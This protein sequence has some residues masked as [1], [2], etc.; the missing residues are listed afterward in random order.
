MFLPKHT[1]AKRSC[2][3]DDDKTELLTWGKVKLSNLVVT[4]ILGGCHTQYIF[5][6]DQICPD[7]MKGQD[8]DLLKSS[9]NEKKSIS[10]K[11]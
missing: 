8:M 1:H 4:G 10:G 6:E 9:E 3:H 5:V 11:K 2:C 7:H